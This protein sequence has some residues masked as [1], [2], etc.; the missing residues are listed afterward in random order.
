M[1]GAARFNRG[2]LWATLSV[3]SAGLVVKLFAVGKETVV[4]AL[5]GRSDAMDAFLAAFLIPNL[6]VNLI[7][8]SMN[9]ALVPTLVRVRM[10]QGH[11][12]AQRLLSSSMLWMCA[13]LVAVCI[14]MALGARFYF[15]LIAW[16]FPHAKLDLA[17][18]LFYLLLPM[19]VFSGMASNCAAVLNTTNQFALPALAPALIPLCAMS[20]ALVLDRRLGIWALAISTLAGALI[21][22]GVMAGATWSRGYRVRLRWY[23]SNDATREVAR[24]FGPVMLSSVVASGG[25][26]VDQA[27]AAALPSGSVSALVFGGRFASV[28]VSLLAGAVSTALAPYFSKIVAERDWRECRRAL[29]NWTTA[30]AGVGTPLAVAMIAGSGW[31]VRLTL[32]HGSFRRFDTSEVAPVLAMYAIQIPFFA[33][34][35]VFYRFV[36]AMGRADLVF[37]CGSLNLILNVV[38]DVVLMRR[39][40]VAGLA[41][42]TS[43]WT[44]S[45]CVFLGYWA[46]RLLRGVEQRQVST[47]H[48]ENP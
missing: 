3:A 42:A 10:R 12:C 47:I 33:A 19:V 2:V 32:Q 15:P 9:Q 26:L 5:Y 35:R 34:S 27:M 36:L 22:A 48:A 21:H 13:V 46:N 18:R 29:R 43:M 45:T 20:G 30:A 39:M 16:N 6:L 14:C 44:V 23:G 7:A 24:Q 8:E 25:L 28:V 37:Y 38:L 41:L 4:A 1:Q 11:E 40:G 31:L 17:I